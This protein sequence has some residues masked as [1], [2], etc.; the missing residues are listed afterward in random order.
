M[1]VAHAIPAHMM[2]TLKRKTT[3]KTPVSGAAL[4]RAL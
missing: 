1:A 4:T 3:K 2:I